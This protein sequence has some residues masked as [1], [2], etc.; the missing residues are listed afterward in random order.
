MFGG[1]YS[2]VLSVIR[3]WEPKQNYNSELK[4][5]D[6]LISFLRE[7]LNKTG[8]PFALGPKKRINLKKEDGRGLCDIAVDGSI[9]VELKRNLKGKSQIDRLLGQVQRYKRFYGHIIIVLVGNISRDALDDLHDALEDLKGN[10]M[11]LSLTPEPDI[12]VVDKSAG[13]KKKKPSGPFG[14]GI[15]TD[16]LW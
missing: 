10:Q 2:E 4:F 12:K 7:E 16:R 9:G 1:L 8:S 14:L 5:R 11:G 6:D 13:T 15:G 3:A